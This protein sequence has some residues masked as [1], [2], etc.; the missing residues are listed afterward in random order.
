MLSNFCLNK[1]KSVK[2]ISFNLVI[3][4]FKKEFSKV[5]A[6]II[7]YQFGVQEKRAILRHF[8]ERRVYVKLISEWKHQPPGK[9]RHSIEHIALAEI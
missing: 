2:P 7:C 4:F 9:R 5:K 3:E 1:E 6:F 8:A